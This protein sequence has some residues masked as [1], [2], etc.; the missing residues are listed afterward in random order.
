[1]T[2]GRTCRNMNSPDIWL[3]CFMLDEKLVEMPSC[4]LEMPT[5]HRALNLERNNLGHASKNEECM[6]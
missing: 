4:A 6:R 2:N 1:M 3:L 5:G